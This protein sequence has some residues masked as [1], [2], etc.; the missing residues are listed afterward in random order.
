M[1]LQILNLL[2][3]TPDPRQ[4]GKIQ[5]SVGTL[6]F[7]TLCAIL[8]GAQTW[9]DIS[10][11]AKCKKEWLS[12]YV[13]IEDTVPS[14]WT[15]RRFFTLIEPGYL[16]YI[17]QAHADYIMGK[18]PSK[19]IS[20]DGKALCNSKRHNIKC[21]KSL[22]AWCNDNNLV[23]SETDVEN[24]SNEKVAIPFLLDVL[25][26]K[27]TT[28]SID[29]AGCY[30]DIAARI[31]E[32]KGHY[33]L[34]LK[35]NQPTLYQAIETHVETIG[36]EEG[37][38]LHDAFDDSHGRTVRRRYF[39]YDISSLPEIEGW[40]D[41]KTVVA[42]ET[43]SSSPQKPKVVANW[44]Y[45]ISSHDFSNQKLPEYIR[46]H[47]AIENKLHWILDVHLGE[48]NDRKAERRSAKAFAILKR[49]ALNIVRSKQ[50]K[51]SLR[52]RLKQAGWN[53]SYLLKL[54]S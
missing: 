19:Q 43:I 37:L 22:T 17:L 53:D 3:E 48:D 51:G 35:K 47:W 8:C 33:V 34:A 16:A 38:K 24:K 9:Q 27:K 30:K 5:Y 18:E 32:K 26:L 10:L 23:L 1:S 7:T 13:E 2:K 31:R 29:A 46:N 21:L 6:L 25:N 36:H 15:F 41:L 11:F 40:Q 44:R 39:S 45:Y 42:I 20:I 14:L 28:V 12:K 4:N 50:G 49:M 54:L 52:G